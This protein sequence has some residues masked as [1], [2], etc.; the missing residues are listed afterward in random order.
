MHGF[1]AF[2][3]LNAQYM[4]SYISETKLAVA[5]ETATASVSW[6]TIKTWPIFHQLSLGPIWRIF[7]L[8]LI[9]SLT[10]GLIEKKQFTITWLRWLVQLQSNS[11]YESFF[12]FVYSPIHLFV[13][14]FVHSLADYSPRFTFGLRGMCNMH[15]AFK[16]AVNYT[17]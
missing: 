10:S 4:R 14:S 8:V 7:A 17:I 9:S 15:I 6:W 1:I 16:A 3:E 5:L 12:F 11:L 2:N 13:R